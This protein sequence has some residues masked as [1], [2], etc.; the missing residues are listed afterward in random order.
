MYV[1]HPCRAGVVGPAGSGPGGRDSP[2]A[3]PATRLTNTLDLGLYA[4]EIS[5]FRAACINGLSTAVSVPAFM[6]ARSS[7]S[8]VVNGERHNI[9]PHDVDRATPLPS[10]TLLEFL[11]G[12]ILRLRGS[13]QGCGSGICGACTVVLTRA[14]AEG[15]PPRTHA[16]NACIFP[17]ALADGAGTQQICS[18]P[19]VRIAGFYSHLLCV[20]RN[21]GYHCRGAW[22]HQQPASNP[23]TRGRAARQPVRLLY[24]G[25]CDV[26]VRSITEW[27]RQ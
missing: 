10:M 2:D 14:G 27:R 6:S 3:N 19:S 22:E 25:F 21:S 17:L 9:S 16:V 1:S 24:A 26:D 8:L 18:V 11:R 13:K 15:Q 7:I 23:A 4:Q 12:P 5:H 20:R